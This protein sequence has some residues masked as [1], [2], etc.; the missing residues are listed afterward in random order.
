MKTKLFLTVAA[1]ISLSTSLRADVAADNF[2]PNPTFELGTDLD[3]PTGTP[4]FWNRGGDDGSILQSSTENSV[5]PTHSLAINKPIEGPYGEWYSDLSLVGL[6]VFGD[7]VN[8]HW[9]EIYSISGGEMRLTVRFLDAGGNGPDNHFVVSGDSSG[10][11]GSAAG[12]T[13]TVRDE[14]LVINTLDAITMRIQLVS[15]G[16]NTTT[17]IYLIDDLVVVPEPSS[18]ALVS[19][20]GLALMRR[21]GKVATS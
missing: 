16:G 12:S 14:P 17:G 8:L 19:I 13:F 5:S 21:R 7:T 6:A 11:A 9:H 18:I 1:L 15:G 3:L 10:W 4:D 2:W 20:G